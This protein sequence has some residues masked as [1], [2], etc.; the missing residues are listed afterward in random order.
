MDRWK[1]EDREELGGEENKDR[2]KMRRR[3]EEM[4]FRGTRQD[5]E[6]MKIREKRK[7]NRKEREKG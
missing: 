1:G 5:K 3:Y 7:E 2:K 6:N 4:R